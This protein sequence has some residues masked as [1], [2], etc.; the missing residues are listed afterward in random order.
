MIKVDRD[1]F[2]G[3]LKKNGLITE[4]SL[5]PE[6][7][8]TEVPVPDRL[9]PKSLG[10]RLVSQLKLSQKIGILLWVNN[11]NELTDGGKERLL[12]LQRKASEE[13]ILAGMKFYFRL[14]KESKLRSDFNPHAKELNRRPQSKRFRQTVQRRIGV[15]Y[16]DKGTLPEQS[17]RERLKVTEESYLN[18]DNLSEEYQELLLL[19][20]PTS[21]DEGWVDLEEVEKRSQEVLSSLPGLLFLLN[22]L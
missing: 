15:G 14:L 19:I 7:F 2:L 21:L 1:N 3:K 9:H 12:Y 8:E 4:T 5:N 20:A 22:Q 18:F 16:R 6:V 11:S 17:S 13:A 10:R